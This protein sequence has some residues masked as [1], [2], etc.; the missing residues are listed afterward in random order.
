MNTAAGIAAG[1]ER[2]R[3]DGAGEAVIA[4]FRGAAEQLAAGETGVLRETDIDPVSELPDAAQLPDP[5]SQIAEL[6]DATV[7]IKL[8]GGLGTSMGMTRAKSLLE[9]K[10]GKSFLDIAAT[11]IERLRASFGAGAPRIPLVLMNSFATRADSLAA[12]AAYP[13]ISADLPADMVQSRVPKLRDDGSL[14]PVDWPADPALQ[15]A[16]PGHG[17][18]YPTLVAS[19]LLAALIDRGYRY[20]FVSN[21]DNLGAVLDPRILGWFAGER[22]PFLMEAADR[23]PADRKGGH[24]AR[25]QRGGLVLREVAQTAPADLGVFQDISRHRFFNTNSVWLDL[26]ELA[27]VLERD[28]FLSLPL[29]VNR[30]TVD[31]AASGSA[32]VVQMETAMGAAI[33]AFPGARALRVPRTRF[34]PVKTTD[35]LLVLRSDA[36]RL[37]DM[38]RLTLA[39]QRRGRAP[40][41]RLDA[42]FYRL[43]GDFEQRFPGGPPS[44]AACDALPVTGDVRFGA[45][46]IARGTVAIGEPGRVTTVP[47][48]TVLSG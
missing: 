22:V 6:L 10:D 21:A 47:D 43:L 42:P 40:L 7:V 11:Q 14:A 15:W 9:V 23:T 19:G 13:G 46:V 45:G 35:D 36:Y 1:V 31:P 20:A 16:P 26:R 34:V 38:A 12:L 5:G 4:A 25:H 37:D 27:A 32:P 8:N 44:L 3:A 33:A 41:A 29:I 30:K 2:L 48:G 28:G 24:L 18:L 17:D 39:E